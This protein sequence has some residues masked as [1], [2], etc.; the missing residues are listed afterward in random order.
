MYPHGEQLNQQQEF[1]EVLAAE[2]SQAAILETSMTGPELLETNR[3]EPFTAPI[4]VDGIPQ[5][6]L[7][8]VAVGEDSPYDARSF[9]KQS[10]R[11]FGLVRAK[12]SDQVGLVAFDP[13]RSQNG[14]VEVSGQ[15]VVYPDANGKVEV[16]TSL[17]QGQ[18]A[19][20]SVEQDQRGHFFSY[21]NYTDPDQA[22][23]L[24]HRV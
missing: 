13:T 6:V 20:L 3:V 15:E 21:N 14:R 11:L 22:A 18:E 9:L 2:A 1:G 12:Y 16:Q 5:D 24:Y 19:Y 10:P 17:K 4:D 7:A 8:V 23:V